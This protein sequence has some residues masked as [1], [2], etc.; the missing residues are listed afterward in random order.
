MAYYTVVEWSF[1]R[2]TPDDEQQIRDELEKLCELRHKRLARIY[3]FHWRDDQLLIFR[4]HVPTGTIADHLRKGALNELVAF[5][6]TLQVLDALNY[7]HEQGIVH[8]KVTTSNMLITLSNDI[9]LA[10]MLVKQLPCVQK[11]Q[12]LLSSPP[13]AFGVFDDFPKLTPASDVW[14]AGCA[15]VT[16]LT[17]SAPFS[18]HFLHF[19]GDKLHRELIRHW[20]KNQLAFTSVALLPNAG[21]DVSELVD[22]IFEID[23]DRRPPA[24]HLIATFGHRCRTSSLLNFQRINVE[25]VEMVEDVLVEKSPEVPVVPREG[26]I[27]FIRWILSRILI[28]SILLVKWIAMVFCAALSLALVAG[29]V[30]LS[31][32]VIYNG[33]EM[34]CRC[35]LNEGFIVLIALILLPIIILLTTLC[36]NNSLEKYHHDVLSGKV[37]RSWFVAKTPEKDIAFFGYLMIKGKP[38]EATRKMGVSTGIAQLMGKTDFLSG[39]RGSGSG[40]IGDRIARYPQ[41]SSS[42]SVDCF[43]PLRTH[44]HDWH[45]MRRNRKVLVAIAVALIILTILVLVFNSFSTSADSNEHEISVGMRPNASEVRL[46]RDLSLKEA[47]MKRKSS[48]PPTSLAGIYVRDAYRVA[49]D[50]IRI[51]YLENHDNRISLKAEIPGGGWQPIEWF[52]FNATCMDYLFCTMATRIG[53]VRLPPT[54]PSMSTVHVSVELSD[55]YTPIAVN[56]VRPKPSAAY[57]HLVGVCVQPIF[58]FTDWTIIIQFFESWL[59][60]GATKFYFYVHSYTR[61]TKAVLD[62]Y[63]KTL[64]DRLELIEWS[65]LPV[66][67]RERGDYFKDPN[68]RVFRHAATAFMHDCL[69]RARSHVKF[70]SNTDLDDLPLAANLNISTTLEAAAKRHPKAAQ[71][72]IDWIL[73]HQP[74]NWDA[75]SRPAD[76]QFEL[77]LAKVLK[78]EHIRWDYRVSKKI[79][80]RPERVIHFDMHSVYRNEVSEDDTQYTTVEMF[81]SPHL[82]FLHLRRFERRLLNPPAVE[83]NNSFDYSLLHRLNQRMHDNYAKRLEASKQFEGQKLAPW[84]LEA[85]ETMRNL[86]QCRREAFGTTLDD[87]NEMCQQS[88]AGCEGMLTAGIQFIKAPLTWSNLAHKALFNDYV[89]KTRKTGFLGF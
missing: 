83:Y 72:K 80:H 25:E 7:L 26:L 28:F 57:E 29:T 81:D 1:D 6:Y 63:A 38:R 65:D 13:E 3:G 48:S 54:T 75:I 42:S 11:R 16:M 14:A 79:F 88:S 60:Q 84:A 17:R 20:R 64:G 68:A 19:H 23:A 24:S 9:L 78:I 86:E 39:C 22:T 67:A 40:S 33:I 5:R 41:V 61:Q 21:R 10:D 46:K 4:T 44:A 35:R 73:T 50:E 30:F 56:D 52:C 18:D 36:C 12:A 71:F 77:N 87:K 47:W 76:V 15:L 43:S 58:F 27:A 37:E 8:G 51:I 70:I 85:R 45:A 55:E 62:F 34:V 66:H 74:Q 53:I 82:L 2:K 59:A 89:Q 49:D 32:F 31:I 69:L